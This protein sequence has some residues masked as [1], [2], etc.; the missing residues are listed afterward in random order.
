VLS[1][2]KDAGWDGESDEEPGRNLEGVLGNGSVRRLWTLVV[3][4]AK[5][6]SS[7]TSSPVVLIAL[8]RGLVGV[9]MTK[10]DDRL[11]PRDGALERC[12]WFGRKP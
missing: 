9:R 3:H 8:T 7:A 2:R 5:G 12:R 11:L 4:D 1:L 6:S 10:L